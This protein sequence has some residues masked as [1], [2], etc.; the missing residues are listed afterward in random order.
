[1]PS[2]SYN[3]RQPKRYGTGS[4]QCPLSSALAAADTLALPR[5]ESTAL[6]PDSF[7]V[8]TACVVSAAT[9][10]TGNGKRLPRNSSVRAPLHT[11]L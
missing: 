3:L 5:L 8:H 7:S 4:N 1:M 10:P 2:T 9:T 11:V 6:L